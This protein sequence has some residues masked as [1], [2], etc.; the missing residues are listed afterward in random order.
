MSKEKGQG[1]VI[2]K[3]NGHEVKGI[4]GCAGRNWSVP[5]GVYMDDQGRLRACQGNSYPVPESGL[6][7]VCGSSLCVLSDGRYYYTLSQKDIINSLLSDEMRFTLDEV[8][9]SISV[10]KPGLDDLIRGA[11]DRAAAESPGKERTAPELEH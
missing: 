10:H 11:Q 4:K 6:L 8:G 3:I 7:H 9:W 5:W 2:I 1:K